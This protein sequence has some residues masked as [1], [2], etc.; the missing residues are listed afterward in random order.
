MRDILIQILGAIKALAPA[1]STPAETTPEVTESR[2]SAKIAEEPTI[3]T[4]VKKRSVS[5]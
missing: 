2:N 5:K 1:E 4:T 3:Q